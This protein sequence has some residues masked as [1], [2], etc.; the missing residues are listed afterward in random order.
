MHTRGRPPAA[1]GD[2]R[3]GKARPSNDDHR[4]RR[5]DP[6][7]PVA[8]PVSDE[9]APRAPVQL[10]PTSLYMGVLEA[11]QEFHPMADWMAGCHL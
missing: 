5:V 1:M 10:P 4:P 7:A 2:G 3:G 8:A 11:R 9:W 6:L